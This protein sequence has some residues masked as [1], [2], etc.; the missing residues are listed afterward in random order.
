MYVSTGDPTDPSSFVAISDEITATNPIEQYVFDLSDYEGQ[1]G[2]IAI[3]HFNVSDMFRLNIDDVMIG[4]PAEEPEWILVEDVN[5]PYIIEGLTPETM[6][7]VQVQAV[8]PATRAAGS[9]E[10]VSDWTESTIFTTTEVSTGIETIKSEAQGD[11]NYYNLM[12]QKM[13]G[14]NL[15]AGI[16]IHNGKKVV[17]K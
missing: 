10:E 7:E 6:Y 4:E 5:N 15:P 11:N 9:E 16:Y 13:N 1:E 3:R 14:S 12:G 8:R 2:Y 17:V